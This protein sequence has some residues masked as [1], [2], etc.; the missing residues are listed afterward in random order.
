MT[1]RLI[2][3]LLFSGLAA[4]T[5]CACNPSLDEDF[6]QLT[7]KDLSVA[8]ADVLAAKLER[9]ETASCMVIEYSNTRYLLGSG[10]DNLTVKTCLEDVDQVAS[11][12]D[13]DGTEVYGFLSGAEVLYVLIQTGADEPQ[14]RYAEFSCW[15]PFHLNLGI[16]DNAE[17]TELIQTIEAQIKAAK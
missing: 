14:F 12:S 2:L 7:S 11:L 5:A 9:S 6:D 3:F 13:Y 16:M 1:G 8:I 17:R 10:P 4:D 15:G